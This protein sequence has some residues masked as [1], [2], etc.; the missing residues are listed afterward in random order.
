VQS[1]AGVIQ[2]FSGGT[3][4]RIG[5]R[6]N[7]A[8]IARALQFLGTLAIGVASQLAQADPIIYTQPLNPAGLAYVSQ[9]DPVTFPNNVPIA[10]TYDDFIFASDTTITDVHWTGAILIPP[11]PGFQT[12]A[13]TGFTIQFWNDV[14]GTGPPLFGPGPNQPP[15]ALLTDS[16]SGNAGETSIGNCG[17]PGYDC[18]TYSANLS[19]PFNATGGTKY[20]LSIVPDLLFYPEWGW[21]AGTGGDGVAYFDLAAF[22]SPPGRSAIP[23]D[24]AFQLSGHDASVPEPATL[25]LLGLGLAGLGFSRRKQ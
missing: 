2:F 1:P 8:Y 23:S 16:V 11:P 5:L 25:A 15:A 10:R 19:V 12:N 3:V 17:A 20:W 6:F 14:A 9:S 21:M 22:T 13:I 7:P 24:M 18:F 4:L